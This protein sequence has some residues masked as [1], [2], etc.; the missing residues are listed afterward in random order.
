MNDVRGLRNTCQKAKEEGLN[1]VSEFW[2]EEH[3]EESWRTWKNPEDWDRNIDMEQRE[4]YI[5]EMKIRKIAIRTSPDILRWG[6]SMKANFTIKEAYNLITQQ[7]QD[8][9]TLLW[10]QIWQGNWWPKLTH[11]LWLVGKGHI[12]KW[13]QLQKRGIQCPPRCCLCKQDQETQEHVL[14]SCLFA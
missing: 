3:Q 1:Y 2:N 7:E 9:L 14:N 8:D 11:F 13:D 4:L 5:K 6:H 12:L 10:K